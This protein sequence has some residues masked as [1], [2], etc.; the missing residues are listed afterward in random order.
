MHSWLIS[1]VISF[2]LR[3]LAKFT[4]SIDWDK[5][6]KDLDERVRQIVPG[7]WFDD[8]AVKIVDIAFLTIKRVLKAQDKIQSILQLLAEQKFPEAATLL[9]RILTE[10]LNINSLTVEESK[11]R[12]I[13]RHV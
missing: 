12:Q 8:E 5:V 2:V 11:F 10:H 6:Q 9:K 4:D 13:L 3:Q 7:T 1:I